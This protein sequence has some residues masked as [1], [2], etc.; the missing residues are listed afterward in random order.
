M[1]M[2]LSEYGAVGQKDVLYFELGV[3]C[4]NAQDVGWSSAN[5]PY[6]LNITKHDALGA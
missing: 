1:L 6:T 2:K 4:S 3:A 5:N